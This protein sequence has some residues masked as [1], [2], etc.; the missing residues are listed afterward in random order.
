MAAITPIDKDPQDSA[1][2]EAAKVLSRQSGA[3]Q[4]STTPVTKSNG[5]SSVGGRSVSG[6]ARTKG[7]SF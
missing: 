4:R 3:R 1:D 7:G 6:G 5:N 2:V